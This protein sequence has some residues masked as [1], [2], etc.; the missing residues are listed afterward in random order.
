MSNESM[1]YTELGSMKFHK[2]TSKKKRNIDK[3]LIK[4]WSFITVIVIA[5]VLI[6][7]GMVKLVR[8]G[9]YESAIK[10][11]IEFL[12]DSING[13][14]N[15]RKLAKQYPKFMAE[16][17]EEHGDDLE[18]VIE[19]ISDELEI[20]SAIFTYEVIDKERSNDEEIEEY[21]NEISEFVGEDEK[22]RVQKGYCFNVKIK[23]KLVEK[24]NGD[25]IE[26]DT[27]EENVDIVVLKCNGKTGVW[28]IDGFYIWDV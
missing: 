14:V 17:I 10:K 12:N 28:K 23:F 9:S 1:G 8:G 20:E 25:E 19:Y 27:W 13:E 6:V 4:K 11:Y 16:T 7:F 15:E 3:D 24:E 2:E 21:Q 22:V 18:E 5:I 26:D